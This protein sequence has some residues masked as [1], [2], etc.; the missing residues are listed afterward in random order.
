MN[1]KKKIK[2]LFAIN[3]MN[4]GGAP[5]V[6]FN[7]MKEL[8]K[9]KFDPYILTLYPS[10]KANFWSQMDFLDES[11]IKNFN[12][13]NRSF[14]DFKTLF[15]IFNYL[16][17]ENFDVVYTHL[18][19]PNL[20]IR[21]FAIILRTKVIVSFEHS[22]YYYKK[23]WHIVVEKILSFFTDKIITPSKEIAKF[24]SKQ[25]NISIN[26]FFVIPNPISIP[27]R[28]KIDTDMLRK[29]YRIP[30]DVF[31]VM[32]LG[33]FSSEKAQ[34]YF[35]QVAEKFLGEYKNFYFLILGHG[36]LA[37]DLAKEIGDKGVGDRCRLII[38]PEIAKEF[39]FIAD[40]FVSTSIKEGH[41][42]ALMEAMMAGVP[43]VASDIDGNKSIIKDG[44]N[45]LLFKTKDIEDMYKKILLLYKNKIFVEKLVLSAEKTVI[46]YSPK[47]NVIKFEKL[48][49]LL[50]SKRYGK[51]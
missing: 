16:R 29:K 43:I 1:T 49:K 8:D 46:E 24:T 10:K 14:F 50:I 25:E 6:V 45:G 30:E 23:R 28:K 22:F 36:P 35:I 51:F 37:E 17:K 34:T 3:C 44:V 21:F 48:L 32:T 15:K 13:K 11:R 9:E 7:Q 12:L 41:P 20:I 31:I 4:I 26:R 40:L 47:N 38:E 33:R 42:I 5:A 19:L 39:L 2:V 18:F 27:E